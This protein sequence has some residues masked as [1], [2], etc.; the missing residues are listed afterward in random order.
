MT[1]L[2]RSA[3]AE[4]IGHARAC[5]DWLTNLPEGEERDRLELGVNALLTPALMV[6]RGYAS[7]EVEAS[8]RRGLELL[9]ALGERPEMF[10][11]SG[12]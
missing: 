10:P 1:A 3:N 8:A 6:S 7:A 4:A 12:A 9:D 11:A 2:T 5:L